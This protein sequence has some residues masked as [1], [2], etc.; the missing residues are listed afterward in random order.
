[1]VLLTLLSLLVLLQCAWGSS[2]P[3][4][5]Y[6]EGFEAANL[7]GFTLDENMPSWPPDYWAV[8]VDAASHS[9]SYSMYIQI[10]HGEAK[11]ESSEFHF[12]V[13]T[14]FAKPFPI[15]NLAGTRTFLDVWIYREGE[16]FL[17]SLHAEYYAIEAVVDLAAEPQRGHLKLHYVLE[18]LNVDGIRPSESSD[19]K[20]IFLGESPSRDWI[21]ILRDLSS[22]VQDKFGQP[23]LSLSVVGIKLWSTWR[24]VTVRIGPNGNERPESKIRFDD[25]F[26]GSIVSVDP[27][28][29]FI[30]EKPEVLFRV[31]AG[32][33]SAVS[34]VQIFI[35]A[36]SRNLDYDDATGYWQARIN[37]NDGN[38]SWGA[39][40]SYSTGLVLMGRTLRLTVTSTLPSVRILSPSDGVLV[41]GVL[42]INGTATGRP[43]LREVQVKVDDGM[44]LEAEGTYSWAFY[45]DTRKIAEDNHTLFARAIDTIGRQS[46]SAGISVIVDNSPPTLSV[47]APRDGSL[48]AGQIVVA[49]VSNDTLSGTKEVAIRI[50]EVGWDLMQPNGQTWRAALD[51][52]Q[53]ADGNHTL[54]V[55]ASDVA[56]NTKLTWIRFATDNTP[57][58]MSV[59]QFPPEHIHSYANVSISIDARDPISGV[60]YVTLEYSADGG[61]TWKN[62]SITRNAP[63]LVAEI[64]KQAAG[65]N[66]TYKVRCAD[67]AG[68]IVTARSEYVVERNYVL[69]ILSHSP[70]ENLTGVPVRIKSTDLTP[71]IVLSGT[72]AGSPASHAFSLPRG[73]YIVEA[74]W[75][76]FTERRPVNFTGDDDLSFDFFALSA[77][78]ETHLSPQ[79]SFWATQNHNITVRLLVDTRGMS[80]LDGNHTLTVRGVDGLNV[81]PGSAVVA[82]DGDLWVV[83]FGRDE[84]INVTAY[85]VQTNDARLFRNYYAQNLPFI[86]ID[87]QA[88]MPAWDITVTFPPNSRIVNS[89]RLLPG[90]GLPITRVED[91]HFSLIYKSYVFLW[92]GEGGIIAVSY[93]NPDIALFFLSALFIV[94]VSIAVLAF[95]TRSPRVRGVLQK[96]SRA[97]VVR[98]GGAAV[99]TWFELYLL[100]G[101]LMITLSY[102]VGVQQFSVLPLKGTDLRSQVAGLVTLLSFCLVFLA[103]YA[104]VRS[105][106]LVET[107]SPI[108]LVGSAVVAFLMFE[109]TSWLLY[110]CSSILGVPLGYHGGAEALTG[111]RLL[112]FVGGGNIP[113]LLAGFAGGLLAVAGELSAGRIRADLS[114][115]L[116]LFLGLAFGAFLPRVGQVI[117]ETIFVF[118]GGEPYGFYYGNL[119]DQWYSNMAIPF[120]IAPASR[121]VIMWFAMAVAISALPRL[122]RTINSLFIGFALPLY[123]RGLMRTGQ[124]EYVPLTFESVYAG[125]AIGFLVALLLIAL[126]RLVKLATARP[127]RVSRIRL[128]SLPFSGTKTLIVLIAMTGV[129]VLFATRYPSFILDIA[130]VSLFVAAARIVIKRT[131]AESNRA[132]PS[133]AWDDHALGRATSRCISKLRKTRS[134]MSSYK[135]GCFTAL[136]I[137]VYY[138]QLAVSPEIWLGFTVGYL[139][140]FFLPGYMLANLVFP[141][142]E[143]GKIRG[144][145]T[146]IVYI[147]ISTSIYPALYLVYPNPSDLFGYVA[148]LTVTSG[149]ILTAR[150]F[151]R[152]HRRAQGRPWS[153]APFLSGRTRS[154]Q[155]EGDDN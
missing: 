130:V 15:A 148:I 11:A 50:D 66:I 80:A 71:P 143:K 79:Y 146:L 12:G 115:I 21:E 64:P 119:I 29:G 133:V 124:I 94:L 142:L 2:N 84:R 14:A 103:S 16:Q 123:S 121:G 101:L 51:T 27:P 147:A 28:D 59:A 48:L 57:P 5:S 134:A 82:H 73:K 63:Y 20:Y 45:L 139:G 109:T 154:T 114:I 112:G 95:A 4:S 132:R 56:G 111:P 53:L 38:Y 97:I 26:L 33:K 35:N 140:A 47:E 3:P 39:K 135:V 110:Y 104:F 138:L 141:E 36:T 34:T 131:I 151:S 76:N 67:R 60:A 98:A 90:Y 24:N 93:E 23:D 32:S 25:I 91:D 128:T 125:I 155:R 100:V 30:A 107:R 55:R 113:R 10:R 127:R 8:G 70:N 99:Y 105:V 19:D 118:I 75:L 152:T 9:G 149:L 52:K 126:D 44:W 136:A 117:Y 62:A 87:G 88:I 77:T 72:T 89:A 42:T 68:N 78:M 92:A 7:D 37:L 120:R 96:T 18:V 69:R 116:S 61:A 31:Y 22:D 153:Q 106:T 40:V 150:E 81:S 6:F 102:M 54:E 58:A 65:N 129:L 83:Y 86:A 108:P 46:E 13:Q 43:N 49:V 74:T 145:A 144:I 122:G 41:N 1:M 137:S 85:W 17:D